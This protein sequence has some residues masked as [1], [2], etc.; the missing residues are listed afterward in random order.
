MSGAGN[1]KNKR[2]IALPLI[3][4]VFV[5]FIVFFVGFYIG[6]HQRQEQIISYPNSRYKPPEPTQ[7]APKDQLVNINTASSEQLQ[8]LSGIGPKLAARIIE[9]REH[10]PFLKPEDI[11]KVEGVGQSLFNQNKDRIIVKD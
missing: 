11:Q 9:F 7:M 2:N 8:T 5:M 10:T 4:G 6:R 3:V 1:P